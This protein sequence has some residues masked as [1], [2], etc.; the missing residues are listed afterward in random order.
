MQINRDNIH[1][2]R[3]RVDHDYYVGDKA[4]LNNQAS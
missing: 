4:I 3:N 1:E 2:N